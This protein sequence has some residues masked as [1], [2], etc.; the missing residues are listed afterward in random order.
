MYYHPITDSFKLITQQRELLK[1]TEFKYVYPS[2]N[3]YLNKMESSGV[4]ARKDLDILLSYLI[5]VIGSA[6]GTQTR[7]RNE[8][9][10]YV[11]F[12]WNEKNKSV[13][14]ST[15]EDIRD[16]IDWLWSPPKRLI[17]DNTIASRYKAKPDSD[18]RLV[19]E[20]WRPFVLR[21]AKAN[22]KTNEFI[23]PERA[24]ITKPKQAYSLN[25]TSLQNSYASLNI[26]FKELWETELIS[27]N[28]VSLVKKSCKYL[29]KGKIYKP[30]HT[31]DDET[32]QLFVD[33]LTQAADENP[34]YER[35]RFLVL[36]LKVLF[37]RISELASR[38]Y[39]VP[40]FGHFSQDPSGEGWVLNVIGKGKKQRLVT[41][42]DEFIDHVLIRYRESLGLS[43]LPHIDE[44][45]P[46]M[47]SFKTGQALH[48]DSL[49]NMVEEAFDLVIKSL[50]SLGKNQQAHAI[51]G[52][53]SHWLRHTGATQALSEINETMLAVELGHASVKTTVEVYVAPAH[54]DR[55]KKGV[56][57]KL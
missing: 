56:S 38:D 35:H 30:P 33:T 8:A 17:A 45:M 23:A 22:R 39:C 2:L 12:C 19:N 10:R 55:I 4:P 27:R 13:L 32:W 44:T 26:F 47:P 40:V 29:V 31:L 37:L 41:V 1:T 7:F 52:A 57:R 53:S 54:R 34:L 49:N 25:Q 20:A 28:P 9:E 11:L 5:N 43:P 51:A 18:V 21:G 24:N 3:E 6:K 50:K 36:T 16:Y 46:I 14:K 15:I 48:Q 42:P